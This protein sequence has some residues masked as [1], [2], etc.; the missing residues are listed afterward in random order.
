MHG[1]D[2]IYTGKFADSNTDKKTKSVGLDCR[3]RLPDQKLMWGHNDTNIAERERNHNTWNSD[4]T[5]CL[6]DW[7]SAPTNPL[8]HRVRNHNTWLS[9]NS[10]HSQNDLL[11]NEGKNY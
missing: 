6:M 4:N 3:S 7:N 5:K 11:E 10:V 1:N 9:H 8:N 2:P